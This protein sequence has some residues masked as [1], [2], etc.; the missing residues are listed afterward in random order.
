MD[1]DDKLHSSIQA[2][3]IFEAADMFTSRSRR[4]GR[5]LMYSL[6]S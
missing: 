3:D 6:R 1:D 2:I 5:S 4:T